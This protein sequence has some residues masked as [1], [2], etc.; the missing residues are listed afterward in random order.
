MTTRALRPWTDLVKLHLDVESEVLRDSAF[1][2]RLVAIV[3]RGSHAPG[4][5]RGDA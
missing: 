1:A 5:A 2:I 3:G 4:R